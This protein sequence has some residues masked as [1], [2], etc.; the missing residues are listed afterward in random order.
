MVIAPPSAGNKKEVKKDTGFLKAAL[1]SKLRENVR[2]EDGRQMNVAQAMADRLVNI[3]LYAESNTD[4]IA[5]QKLIYER[6]YGKAAVEK[7][8][9]TKEIPKVIF[10]LKDSQLEQINLAA[11][12]QSEDEEPDA[13]IL[14][15]MD[16]GSEVLA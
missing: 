8:E 4:C 12:S 13:G 14:V 7:V 2:F 5:A 6:I 10:A 3:G 1:V 15:E 11:Q 16:D 9:E